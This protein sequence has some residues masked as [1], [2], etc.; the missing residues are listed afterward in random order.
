MRCRWTFSVRHHRPF[1]VKRF[2][3]C[4]RIS[5]QKNSAAGATATVASSVDDNENSRRWQRYDG[6]STATKYINTRTDT[7]HTHTL[8]NAVSDDYYDRKTG[9]GATTTTLLEQTEQ[10]FRYSIFTRYVVTGHLSVIVLKRRV[11]TYF[12]HKFTYMF[13]YVF[14]STSSPD[15]LDRRC[16]FPIRLIEWSHRTGHL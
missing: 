16:F 11:C 7:V 2:S 12:S 3:S 14:A 5:V 9:C 13:L 8:T 4:F 6:A 15:F 1:S 10:T